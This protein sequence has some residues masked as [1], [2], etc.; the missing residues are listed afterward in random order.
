MIWPAWAAVRSLY[1]LQNST[2]LM[3]CGPRA[4]PTGGAGVAL[5]AGSCSVSTI[6]IFLAT[7]HRVLFRSQSA[8]PG[9]PSEGGAEHA[10]E[11]THVR[12]R[13]RAGDNARIGRPGAAHSFSTWRK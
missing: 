7:G 6:L 10:S 2:M 13:A 1:V 9:G 8:E 11:R 4:V 3:P 5:P 12:E